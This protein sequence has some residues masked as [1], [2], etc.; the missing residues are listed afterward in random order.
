[1]V[2]GNIPME[3]FALRKSSK[4]YQLLR[5]AVQQAADLY[6]DW[7]PFE[8]FCQ[9]L[10]GTAGQTSSQAVQKALERVVNTLWERPDNRKLAEYYYGYQIKEKPSPKDFIYTLGEYIYNERMK[11][12]PGP[13]QNN[14]KAV[15]TILPNG[16]KCLAIPLNELLD[17]L[18]E[19]GAGL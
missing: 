13:A 3:D 4:G 2:I 12:Q 9:N 18:G 6:P 10:A 16:E 17:T 5:R 11:S 19:S 14:I 15:M 1:M 8:V 7:P